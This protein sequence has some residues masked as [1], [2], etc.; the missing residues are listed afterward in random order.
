MRSMQDCDASQ[1]VLIIFGG[2]KINIVTRN[3][4]NLFGGANIGDKIK[5]H[6]GI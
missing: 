3:L 5:L 6:S 1:N 4:L 2:E